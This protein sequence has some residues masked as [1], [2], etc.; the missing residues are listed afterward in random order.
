MAL[1]NNCVVA[2]VTVPDCATA[3]KVAEKVLNAHLVAC[4]NILPAVQSRYWWKGSLQNDTE[5]LLICKLSADCFEAFRQA[6]VAEHPY[7][8]PEVIALPIQSGHEPYLKW[9]CSE[10]KESRKHKGL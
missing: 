6:V 2:W 8:V 4:V 9:I 3:D 5:L 10:T 7:E 1:E